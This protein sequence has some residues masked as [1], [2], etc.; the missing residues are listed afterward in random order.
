MTPA[1]AALLRQHPH[2]RYLQHV[3]APNDG[4]SSTRPISA[5]SL[6]ASPEVTTTP[7]PWSTGSYKYDGSGD[8]RATEEESANANHRY[9]YDLLGRLAKAGTENVGVASGVYKSYFAYTYDGFGNR[10]SRN[11]DANQP[12]NTPASP[13]TNRLTAMHYNAVGALDG[14]NIATNY[15]YD[16]VNMLTETDVNAQMA[17]FAIYTADDE[18][19]ALCTGDRCNWTIRGTDKKVRR[20]YETGTLT[21]AATPAYWLWM[22]DYVYRGGQLLNAQ[23]EDPEGGRLNFHEDH[24]GSTRLI[25]GSGGQQVANLDYEPFGMDL[26]PRTYEIQNLNFERNERMRFTGH[27]RDF[28]GSTNTNSEAYV[29]Y[30]HARYYNASWG[31]F[32]EVDLALDQKIALKAPQMWNRY[33]YVRNNPLSATDPTGRR[34]ALVYGEVLDVEPGYAIV[35]RDKETKKISHVVVVGGFQYTKGTKTPQALVYENAPQKP[36]KTGTA[37]TDSAGQHKPTL[38]NSNDASA[39]GGMWSVRTSEVAAVRSNQSTMTGTLTTR[40]FFESEVRSVVDSI[41]SVTYNNQFVGVMGPTCDC[42]GYANQIL[43]GLKG[44]FVPTGPISGPW[45]FN[46]WKGDAEN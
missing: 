33:S 2:V 3:V 34:E 23:R 32:F 4:T 30:M 26:L 24:L 40:P 22:E 21:G 42:T 36:A 35:L 7:T 11:T 37:L 28:F 20:E 8:V 31:R 16:A 41:G 9:E 45:N 38:V 44:T 25:T 19:L 14:D 39:G 27:E 13:T 43:F 18:R 17:R 15:T 1:D 12:S 29:D 6:V 46:D 10:L 5:E